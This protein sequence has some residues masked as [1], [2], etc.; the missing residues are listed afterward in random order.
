MK[1]KSPPLLNKCSSPTP[2]SLSNKIY[3]P[4]RIIT[5]NLK[6][7]RFS[8]VYRRGFVVGKKNKKICAKFRRALLVQRRTSFSS[9]VNAVI[10]ASAAHPVR[11]S[12][13]E[14]SLVYHL[15]VAR[16]KERENEREKERE[17]ESLYTL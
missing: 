3:P 2:R 16:E 14:V 7:K 15:L 12:G 5:K 4:R 6:K 11:V 10:F 1:E 13:V 8:D 17:K 9:I